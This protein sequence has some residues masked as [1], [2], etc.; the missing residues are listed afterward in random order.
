MKNWTDD[1]KRFPVNEF[2]ECALRKGR[3]E[4]RWCRVI[5]VK[6]RN[7]HDIRTRGIPCPVPTTNA[8]RSYLEPSIRN[9]LRAAVAMTP[10]LSSHVHSAERLVVEGSH[11]FQ[12]TALKLVFTDAFFVFISSSQNWPEINKQTRSLDQGSQCSCQELNPRPPEYK[13][14]MITTVSRESGYVIRLFVNA[15]STEDTIQ[16]R[17]EACTGLGRRTKVNVRVWTCLK[18]YQIKVK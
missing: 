14:K 11:I 9:D 2:T 7:V 6:C 3:S 18:W 16:R 8:P 1:T 4:R 17:M 15:V 10:R 5:S 13:A 12:M